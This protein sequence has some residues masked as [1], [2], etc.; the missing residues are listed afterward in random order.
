MYSRWRKWH[1]GVP[2]LICPGAS[3]SYRWRQ[4]LYTFVWGTPGVLWIC[5]SRILDSVTW[6]RFKIISI[7]LSEY[8]HFGKFFVSLFT[9]CKYS[10]PFN[11]KR[12]KLLRFGWNF[13]GCF[14]F[15]LKNIIFY[16]LIFYLALLK[17][18]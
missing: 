12:Q 16:A 17:S 7:L 1:H 4:L 13:Q 14:L 8:L 11:D 15:Y 10:S 5:R 2:Y 6:E 18:Y 9:S 3:H